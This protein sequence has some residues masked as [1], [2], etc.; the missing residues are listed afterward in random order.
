[1]NKGSQARKEGEAFYS[2]A[3]AHSAACNRMNAT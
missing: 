3:N 1:M 2:F